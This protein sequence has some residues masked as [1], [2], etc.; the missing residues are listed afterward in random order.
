[1]SNDDINIT[2]MNNCPLK[3][4]FSFN[5]DPQSANTSNSNRKLLSVVLRTPLPET[6]STDF[7]IKGIYSIQ[8]AQNNA[9]T[10]RR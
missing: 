3:I 4:I 1:M 8:L 7:F 6:Y 9:N 5:T 2:A 10:Y